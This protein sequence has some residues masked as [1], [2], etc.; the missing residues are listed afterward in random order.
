MG[1]KYLFSQHNIALVPRSQT[2]VQHVARL[3]AR[4]GGRPVSGGGAS[5]VQ[6]SYLPT[7]PNCFT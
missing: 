7:T 2:G 1:V 5:F 3:P 6:P 4:E